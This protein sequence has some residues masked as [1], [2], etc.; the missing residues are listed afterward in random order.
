[1]ISL[2]VGSCTRRACFVDRETL[3]SKER[4]SRTTPRRGTKQ[5]ARRQ[6]FCPVSR[7]Q[8]SWFFFQSGSRLILIF[9]FHC[10]SEKYCR[11]IFR[12]ASYNLTPVIRSQKAAG[13]PGKERLTER[14]ARSGATGSRPVSLS[15]SQKHNRLSQFTS[16]HLPRS[17]DARIVLRRGRG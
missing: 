10:T 17:K 2:S 3:V 13:K 14:G 11:G 8:V 15:L 1:V 5:I 9:I 6:P 16:I 12:P 4:V 7:Y